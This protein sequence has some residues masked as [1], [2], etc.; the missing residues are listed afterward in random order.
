M[1]AE[2]AYNV[3]QAL[4]PQEQERMLSMLNQTVT[5]QKKEVKSKPDSYYREIIISKFKRWNQKR[6]K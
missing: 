6:A 3:F 2:T 1:I 5:E 4:S